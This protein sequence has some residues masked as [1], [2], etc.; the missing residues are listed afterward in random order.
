MAMYQPQDGAPK[1]GAAQK[2]IQHPFYH[3]EKKKNGKGYIRGRGRQDKKATSESFD[4]DEVVDQCYSFVEGNAN[5]SLIPFTPNTNFNGSAYCCPMDN[6]EQ[7][8]YIDPLYS[9]HLW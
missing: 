2:R 6:E 4:R 1:V 9:R 7:R 8:E 5:K 3:L